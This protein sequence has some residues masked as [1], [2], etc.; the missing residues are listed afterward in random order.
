LSRRAREAMHCSVTVDADG[1]R[2]RWPGEKL[3]GDAL[4]VDLVQRHR[5]MIQRLCGLLLSDPSEAEDATQ[6]TF[7]LAYESLLSG[8]RPRQ[9]RAWLCAIAR[10]ECW[11]RHDRRRR[12][13]GASQAA[14]RAELDP[15][16]QAV[17]REELATVVAGLSRLPARQKQALVLRELVGLSYRQLAAV[18]ASSESAAEALL[19]RARRSL[20][21]G[22]FALLPL[23]FSL[24]L[25]RTLQRHVRFASRTARAWASTGAQA[26]AGAAAATT[27]IP[28]VAAA[29]LG[30]AGTPV[31]RAKPWA[32]QGPGKTARVESADSTAERQRHLRRVTTASTSRRQPRTIDFHPAAA[33]DP[34]GLT[35]E[36]SDRF[37]AVAATD[38]SAGKPPSPTLGVQDEARGESRRQPPDVVGTRSPPPTQPPSPP[39]S[40][41]DQPQNEPA[42]SMP[43]ADQATDAA[44]T[45]PAPPPRAT[46]MPPK[47]AVTAPPASPVSTPGTALAAPSDAAAPTA[48][49]TPDSATDTAQQ[50]DQ[51]QNEP[52]TSALTA[53][54]TTGTADAPPPPAPS[55]ETPP[56]PAPK[57]AVTA[58]PT[59]PVNRPDTTLT[60]PSDAAAPTAPNAPDSATDT[61]EQADAPAEAAADEPADSAAAHARLHGAPGE[62]GTVDGVTP[63][64]NP[65][66][67]AST[68]QP[69]RPCCAKPH[70]TGT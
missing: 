28:L 55:T 52:A 14:S 25:P 62:R 49:N 63:G 2:A 53:G 13:R 37:H 58:P 27:L 46:E 66:P 23:P 50:A 54:Q 19:V 22:G 48:P 43:T 56:P 34:N 65:A 31:D 40:T 68:T 64:A 38:T 3:E 26:T 29:A 45:P 44:T 69:S 67:P 36:S 1:G 41:S 4:L 39:A 47:E 18:L 6:Q 20:R 24:S 16:E 32:A 11:A 57:E 59:E 10:R 33:A 15:S 17:L 21:R 35:T 70:R 8:V 42:T 61:A 30:G 60:A 5:P 7:L 51:P 9:P 12:E